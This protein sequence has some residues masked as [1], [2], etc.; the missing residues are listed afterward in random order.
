MLA[1]NLKIT[2]ACERPN[3]DAGLNSFS[4]D[5]DGEVATKVEVLE[6]AMLGSSNFVLKNL[7][8]K[9][10]LRESFGDVEINVLEL[11]VVEK[12][13][14]RRAGELESVD[15]FVIGNVCI[16]DTEDTADEDLAFVVEVTVEMP[17][18]QLT[19]ERRTDETFRVFEFLERR[20][21][22]LGEPED[23]E[24]DHMIVWRFFVKESDGGLGEGQKLKKR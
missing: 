6:V 24:D 20:D 14:D 21:R 5:A 18:G 11:V 22:R 13:L 16:V 4:D 7:P 12:T 3:P 9:D 1:T 17:L 19:L 2:A 15:L 23:E 10:S 8:M